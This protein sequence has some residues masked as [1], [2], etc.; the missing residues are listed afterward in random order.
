MPDFERLI[1]D[2]ELSL[3]K[4]E[5]QRKAAIERHKFE[6]RLRIT[7]AISLA[8]FVSISIALIALL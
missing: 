2:F 8:L 6:D 1:R 7:I 3:C 4:T 5:Q